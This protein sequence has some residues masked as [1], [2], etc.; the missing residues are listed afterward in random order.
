MTPE[1]MAAAAPL[2]RL[3]LDE[4]VGSGDITTE[5]CIPPEL[6]G[7]ARII[8]RG[9]TV[10]CGLFL[11]DAVFAELSPRVRCSPRAAEGDRVHTGREILRID[12]PLAALLTGERV[13]LYQR[14]LERLADMARDRGATP[15]YLIP[16]SDRDLRREPLEPPRPAYREAM[17]QIAEQQDALLVDGASPFVGGAASLM[18]DDVHPSTEGHRLLGETLATALEGVIPH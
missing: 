3:A 4:D 7:S 9:P 14:N 11:A 17:E 10:V 5:A 12:G 13:V 15:V 18:L 1:L 8:A 6:Q 2:I 16:P